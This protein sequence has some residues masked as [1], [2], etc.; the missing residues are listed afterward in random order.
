[1]FT[2]LTQDRYADAKALPPIDDKQD[3]TLIAARESNGETIIEFSRLWNTCDEKDNKIEVSFK[4]R[5]FILSIHT[6][7]WPGGG[8]SSP[9]HPIGNYFSALDRLSKKLAYHERQST[10]KVLRFLSRVVT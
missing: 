1:M 6:V 9:P 5:I 10:L 3:Y 7:A 4:S 2:L 8:P